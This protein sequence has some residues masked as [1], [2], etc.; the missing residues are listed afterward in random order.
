M[1]MF[2]SFFEMENTPFGR[3][4]PPEYLYQPEHISEA[5]G[6]L[7]YVAKDQLFAVVT[8]DPGCGKTTLIRDFAQEL[9][10]D[11]YI[12]LYLSDSKLTPAGGIKKSSVSLTRP[13]CWKKRHW[14][15]SGSS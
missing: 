11:D 6:R 9:P 12:L 15:N 10:K 14:R 1:A 2:E 3:N 8:G 4:V 5:K 7:R 13:I